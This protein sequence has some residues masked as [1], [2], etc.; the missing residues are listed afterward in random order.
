MIANIN[1][2]GSFTGKTM[3]MDPNSAAK[4]AI[5]IYRHKKDSLPEV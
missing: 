4:C 2:I 5:D 3:P 1:Q